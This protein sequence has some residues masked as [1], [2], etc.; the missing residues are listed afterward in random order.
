MATFWRGRHILIVCLLAVASLAAQDV[1]VFRSSTDTVRVFV[2]V[3]DR[4][5]GLVAGLTKDDFS[6]SDNGVP[7]PI[8]QFDSTP[9]P[10][11]IVVLLDVSESMVENVLTMR[12]GVEQFLNRLHAED[13]VK[14]GT[15]GAS[16][17]RLDRSY[18]RDVETLRRALPN[19]VIKGQGSPVW[20]SVIGAIESFGPSVADERRVIL[21]VTDGWNGDPV[22]VPINSITAR[23]AVDAAQRAEVTIYSVG[24]MPALS[25]PFVKSIH[26]SVSDVASETGGRYVEIGEGTNSRRVA[27][28]FAGIADDLHA[29][30]LL[31]FEPPQHDGKVHSITV[32]VTR[33]GMQARARRNYIAPGK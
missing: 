1:P 24:M 21:L 30:Y 25:P 29:Q 11:R 33:Q 19:D 14:V 2:S 23:D 17:V 15:F 8:K 27:E 9:V 16:E 26:S 13:L 31:G 12:Q 28:A 6:L 20:R 32:R 5:K 18:T 22:T 10:I 3:T 4:G 7:Q